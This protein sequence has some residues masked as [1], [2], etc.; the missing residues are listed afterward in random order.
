MSRKFILV[1]PD[2]PS[3]ELRERAQDF[4]NTLGYSFFCNNNDSKS[5]VK[6]GSVYYA[7]MDGSLTWSSALSKS[8]RECGCPIYDFSLLNP[9]VEVQLNSRYK[10]KVTDKEVKVGCQAFSF[11]A[12]EELYEAVKK[13]Q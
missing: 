8:D 12:V 5:Y 9:T 7:D 13:Q 11:E 3:R 1:L 10:A 2:N 4:L 6:A